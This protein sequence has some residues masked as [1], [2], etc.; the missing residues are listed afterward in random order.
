MDPICKKRAHMAR[1]VSEGIMFHF[2]P[3][4]LEGDNH[5]VIGLLGTYI[6]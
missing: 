3:S 2:G 1:R 4:A 6:G 5:S